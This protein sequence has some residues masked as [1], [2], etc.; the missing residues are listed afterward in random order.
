MIKWH[1]FIFNLI[2]MINAIFFREYL[3]FSQMVLSLGICYNL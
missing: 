3:F 2:V 1:S